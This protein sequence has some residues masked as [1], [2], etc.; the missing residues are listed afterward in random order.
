MLSIIIPAY[1]E[2]ICIATS[3]ESLCYS[4]RPLFHEL[5]II[6]VDDGSL[7]KT[8]Q[9]VRMMKTHYENKVNIKLIHHI[10]LNR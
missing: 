4:F 8:A 5:E 7:D 3:V 10:T 2:E 9:I 1:N 6:V